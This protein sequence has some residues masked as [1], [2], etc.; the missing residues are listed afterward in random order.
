MTPT[1]V[2]RYVHRITRPTL[3]SGGITVLLAS[4][5]LATTLA[6]LSMSERNFLRDSGWSPVHRTPTEWPSLLA[7]GPHGWAFCAASSLT[8]GLLL[9]AGRAMWIARS[10][11]TDDVLAGAIGIAAVGFI[12]VAFPADYPGA[13]SET[14]HATVHNTIYP[15]IPLSTIILITVV[16]LRPIAGLSTGRLRLSSRLLWPIIVGSFLMT[17]TDGYAQLARF[18]AFSASMIWLCLLGD[19]LLRQASRGA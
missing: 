10:T 18:A 11:T 13:G 8:A 19:S 16:A 6:C 9:L 3:R 17:T 12:G 1:D 2:M 4:A 14:W 5:L 15:L 7:L